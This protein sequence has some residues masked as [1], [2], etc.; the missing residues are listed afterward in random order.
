MTTAPRI[1]VEVPVLSIGA[2]PADYEALGR[3]VDALRRPGG[4]HLTLLHLGIL[5]DFCRD[6]STW[7]RGATSAAAATRWT[8]AWLE[9]LPELAAFSASTDTLI[10]LGS[11]R[12]AGL[13][14]AVPRRVR[15]YQVSLVRALHELLD[16]LGVDNIDDFIL[17]SRALGFRYPRWRPHI[18]VGRPK[19]GAGTLEI[20]PLEIAFGGSRIRNRRFLPA[21][22]AG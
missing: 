9:E 11:G 20:A 8:V 2:G 22:G 16:G 21:E 17:G 18:A 14:V 1:T 3:Y 19:S 15:E 6:V 4:L 10:V 7:T 12:V 13:E 5:E